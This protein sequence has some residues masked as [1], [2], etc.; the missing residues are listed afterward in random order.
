MTLN[1]IAYLTCELK[2][3]DLASRLLIA[4]HLIEQG[5]SVVVGQQ[6][7][8]FYNV[9]KAPPG[10]ILFK[11]ANLIQADWMSVFRKNGHIVLAADEECLPSAVDDYA[12]MTHPDTMVECHSY[13]ALNDLHAQA[14][15]KAYPAHA[16]KVSVA[17]NARVD[18]LRKAAPSRP[19]PDDY[20][21]F[22][23]SFGIINHI[24]GDTQ[25]AAHT[26]IT[27]GGHDVGPE[28]ETMVQ[29]RIDF[30]QQALQETVTL[31]EWFLSNTR[32][33]V[34]I[35]P[36][37]AESPTLWQERYGANDR[38]LIV[39]RSDPVG[40]MKHALL[41]VHSESTTG[42]EAAILGARTLNLSPPMVWRER[43]IVSEANVTVGSAAEAAQLI[44]SNFTAG[45]WPTPKID[46]NRL[47]P[48]GGAERTAQAIARHFTTKEAH[49]EMKWRR[50]KRED[51][52]IQKFTVGLDEVRSLT[53]YPVTPLDDSLFL[54][55]PPTLAARA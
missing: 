1:P 21:L 35:R 2:G 36:H 37:P 50:I 13:L 6:W 54:L 25:L 32:I 16:D 23:T 52:M 53:P 41:M 17:G 27:A 19:M 46:V 34:V 51:Y 12:R 26:W 20:V 29:D 47:F 33:K 38:V 3:R 4:S 24:G 44:F 9:M 7:G 40:W 28:T 11:T 55:T 48:S 43:L 14:I 49:Y 22:N 45:T 10:C 18:I 31:I 42:V 5:Y 39:P 15:A 8:I 30:E